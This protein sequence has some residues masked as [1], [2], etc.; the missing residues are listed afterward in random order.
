MQDV[1]RKINRG[2]HRVL[3]FVAQVAVCALVVLV[4]IN[5]FK[6]YLFRGGFGWAEEVPAVLVA[7]FAF[8]ACA[9]GVRD[10]LH[11]AVSLIYS[12]FRE[13]GAARKILEKLTDFSTLLVGLF[14][15]VYGSM[16][17]QRMIGL[18][19]VLPVTGWPRWVQ[20]ISVPLAGFVITYD[21]I[22]FL[23]GV[24]PWLDIQYP[25]D[26]EPAGEDA[27]AEKKAEKVQEEVQPS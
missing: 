10:H 16:L 11:V 20:Y 7:L 5:V 21:S 3:L 14:M 18:P 25:D 1:L 23:T 24:L 13:G 4:T 19:G 27:A 9:M 17:L 22:L 26:A 2:I 15:L 8:L 6:R 12:R